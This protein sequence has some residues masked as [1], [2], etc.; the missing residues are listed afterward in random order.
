M[1]G[2]LDEAKVE[3]A[4]VL[5]IVSTHDKELALLKETM[6]NC[7]Q[8]F[9]IMGIKDA[10]NLARAFVFQ[11]RK[12]RFAEGWMV[13]MN[14]ISLPDTSLFRDANQIALPNEHPIKVQADDQSEDTDE[15]EGQP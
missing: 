11:A 6:K 10:E 13:A 1:Q 4:E 12:F 2:K 3:L 15:R 8:V 9:Y 5:S 14:G 7:E